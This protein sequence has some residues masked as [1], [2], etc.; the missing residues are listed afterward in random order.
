MNTT[1]TQDMKI[2][3]STSTDWGTDGAWWEGQVDIDSEA[4]AC[5]FDSTPA[6]ESIQLSALPEL[7]D[8]EF[9]TLACQW[10]IARKNSW[11]SPAVDQLLASEIQRREIGTSHL[12]GYAASQAARALGRLGGSSKSS[13]K[14][15]ASRR[16]GAL[17]GRPRKAKTQP[18][19]PAS[20]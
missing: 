9:A 19:K 18:A 20:E 12:V 2:T 3:Y 7:G 10:G 17:G 1:N 4:R 6:V 14:V 15:E 11:T 13:A 5:G 8:D 16:N